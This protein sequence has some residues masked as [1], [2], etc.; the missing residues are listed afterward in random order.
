MPLIPILFVWFI[1]SVIFRL[2]IYFTL[3]TIYF[4][5]IICMYITL[6]RYIRV[7]LSLRI[8][9]CNLYAQWKVLQFNLC[10]K[11]N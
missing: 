2:T 5:Y 11:L 4:L 1:G 8:I 3:T 7:L 10:I 9:L 6:I